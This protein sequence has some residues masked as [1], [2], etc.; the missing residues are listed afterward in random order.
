MTAVLREAVAADPDAGKRLSDLLG[1][2]AGRTWSAGHL[3]FGSGYCTHFTNGKRSGDPHLPYCLQ[4]LFPPPG[5]L[6]TLSELTLSEFESA[7]TATEV[8]TRRPCS[9]R[10]KHQTLHLAHRFGQS[11]EDCARDDRVA[12]VEFDDLGDRR[13]RLDIVIVEAMTG[14]H[15][16]A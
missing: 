2:L 16:Q 10:L 14:M 3:W 1:P 15:R 13:N 4:P 6:L 5:F 11:G 7:W 9:S 12:D 8:P